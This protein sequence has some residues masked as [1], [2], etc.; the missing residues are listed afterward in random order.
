MEHTIINTD[1]II[2]LPIGRILTMNYWRTVK[3]T[4]QYVEEHLKDDIKLDDLSRNAG[5]SQYHYSRI[6]KAEV[7]LS[8][9]DYVRKR[10]FIHALADIDKNQD[11]NMT[12][13][14][15]DYGFETQGGFIKAFRK[16]Y[17]K[18]P[19]SYRLQILGRLPNNIQLVS[20]EKRK[21][22]EKMNLNSIENEVVFS[23]VLNV[24]DKM[25]NITAQN[26]KKYGHAFWE[27]QFIE[28]PEL[29]IYAEDSGK[30]CGLAFG[31]VDNDSVTIAYVGV[32]KDYQG[33]N[34]EQALLVEIENRAKTL[35]YDRLTLGVS[36]GE[37]GFYEKCGYTGNLLI[38]SE[39]NSIDEL[40]S[41]NPGYEEIG[42]NVYEGYVNQLY[43]NIP[44]IDR[45]LQR[46]Y[47]KTFPDCN[48]IMVFGKTV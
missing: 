15:M 10:R 48:T 17:G 26:D 36:E 9:K 18:T 47:E 27:K 23:K 43:L 12:G 44:S 1:D 40:R 14:A 46:K 29:L 6:F 45:D 34:I 31:W 4:L 16:V 35:G 19:G 25:F 41:L 11:K 33:Q 32:E 20:I 28:T 7:G 2:K 37:E 42:A 21:E 5:Y 22:E 13:I 3:K 39:K 38:Q 8:V 24:A 30:I